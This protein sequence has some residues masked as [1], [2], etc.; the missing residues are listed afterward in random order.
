MASQ[1]KWDKYLERR[2]YKERP[3]P[4]EGKGKFQVGDRVFI[5]PHQGN[6]GTWSTYGIIENGY[7]RWFGGSRYLVT[8]EGYDHSLWIDTFY[9]EPEGWEKDSS[10]LDK[11]ENLRLKYETLDEL[12]SDFYLS[13]E[14][15]VSKAIRDEIKRNRGK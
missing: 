10:L 9:L 15:L 7:K 14:E 1:E 4:S 8:P 12:G 11:Y 5:L 3:F 2:E 13:D 6:K